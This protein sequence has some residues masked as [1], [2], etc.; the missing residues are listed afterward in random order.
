MPENQAMR[1]QVSRGNVKKRFSR[2]RQIA[3][4]ADVLNKSRVTI[5][6]WIAEG[7]DIYDPE[8]VIAFYEAK[9]VRRRN[10]MPAPGSAAFRA[11]VGPN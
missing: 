9:A 3:A 7:L 5:R 4:I 11:M 2:T 10:R 6:H 8:A 1:S